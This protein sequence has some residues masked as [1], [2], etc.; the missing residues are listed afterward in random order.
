MSPEYRSQGDA[1]PLYIL[2]PYGF[3]ERAPSSSPTKKAFSTSLLPTIC[4]LAQR[5]VEFVVVIGT[6][7]VLAGMGTHT[8]EIKVRSGKL[9]PP[10]A[11]V[12]ATRLDTSDSCTSFPFGA[13]SARR[14]A[15]LG[16]I[17]GTPT[18]QWRPIECA[19]IE[20]LVIWLSR[21]GKQQSP[22]FIGGEKQARD[23]SL[24]LDPWPC[25]KR[26]GPRFLTLPLQATPPPPMKRLRDIKTKKSV[27]AAARKCRRISP[28]LVTD[29]PYEI[30]GR[31]ISFVTDVPSLLRASE[32]CRAFWIAVVDENVDP[33]CGALD[34]DCGVYMHVSL[35]RGWDVR[36]TMIKRAYAA[37]RCRAKLSAGRGD[38]DRSI[39]A[40]RRAFKLGVGG[41]AK[42]LCSLLVN[43]GH[44]GDPKVL[45][46]DMLIG[47]DAILLVPGSLCCARPSAGCDKDTA[48]FLI[49]STLTYLFRH[50]W[51]HWMAKSCSI[52]WTRIMSDL[53][54]AARPYSVEEL[55]DPT[56]MSLAYYMGSCVPM[57]EALHALFEAF[58][59]VK[60]RFT[61]NVMIG[62]IY[63][64]N[65]FAVRLMRG[66]CDKRADL[67]MPEDMRPCDIERIVSDFCQNGG[68][69]TLFKDPALALHLGGS[70]KYAHWAWSDDTTSTEWLHNARMV[71]AHLIE[72][73]E[74]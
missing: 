16:R 74:M 17:D 14:A 70:G 28:T 68:Q 10:G 54:H 65:A 46:N 51:R 34:I 33:I 25:T 7:K 6:L 61:P 13:H 27:L 30:V 3:F 73:A 43:S 64:R 36:R 47:G 39:D 22:L 24:L 44:I 20:A 58:P 55:V 63:A 60:R 71:R 37:T 1:W 69:F 41:A 38:I 50:V 29:L 2:H 59:G 11:K 31:I 35:E 5:L 18:N 21:Y 53:A 48:R 49:H 66:F 32:S 67:W 72:I 26:Q 8:H 4:D 42:D 40:V 23:K 12:V 9:A 56:A 52:D 45:F 57:Y 19:V 15:G 62:S